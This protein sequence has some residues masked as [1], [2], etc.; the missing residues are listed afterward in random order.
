MLW[1]SPINAEGATST[2]VVANVQPVDLDDQGGPALDRSETPSLGQPFCPTGPELRRGPADFEGAVAAMTGSRP[3]QA[4]RHARSLRV[5]T[6]ISIRFMAQRPSQSSACAAV[7]SAAQ[8][9]WP[10]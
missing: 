3:R 2:Q 10:S 4:A 9:S 8:T 7:Q 1:P 5:D 6:L